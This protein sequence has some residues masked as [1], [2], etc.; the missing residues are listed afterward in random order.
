M[1]EERTVD[2]IVLGAGP[3]G[4]SAPVASH[5]AGWR[6]L[7]SRESSSAASAPTGPACPP[8]RC[9]CPGELA[10]EVRRVPGVR[11]AEPAIDPAG[12]L[13]RRDEVIHD[14]DDSVPVALAGGSRR[15]AHGLRAGEVIEVDDRMR[16]PRDEWLFAIGDVNGRALLTHTGKYQARVAADVILGHD[17]RASADGHLSP[18]VVFTDPQ[19]AAVGHTCASAEQAGLEVRAIDHPT[20]V[21]AGASFHGRGA[22]GL[23]RI[24]I[25][26]GRRVIV[27][28]TF[29]GPDIAELLHAATIAVVG[30]VSLD[31][32]WHTIPSFPTRCEVWL[33]LLEKYGL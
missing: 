25:D 4:K 27:G 2:A 23:A 10:T 19:M 28:A 16:V 13:A 9:F 18:R 5:R 32:L 3:A 30:E 6:S 21:V 31:R 26:E 17:A 33:R 20:G 29:T 11:L 7:S 12:A 1:T 15:H 22:D 14:L 24:L 8:R